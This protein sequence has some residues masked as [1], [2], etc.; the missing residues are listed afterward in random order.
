MTDLQ[1]ARRQFTRDLANGV[2]NPEFLTR[3]G[4]S[5]SKLTAEQRRIYLEEARLLNPSSKNPRRP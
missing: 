4:I 3:P 5:W 1:F 2:L